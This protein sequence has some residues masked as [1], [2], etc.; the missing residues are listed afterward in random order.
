MRYRCNAV[1][2]GGGVRGIGHVGAASVLE[3][4]G[5]RFCNFVGSSAGAIV[6]SL[7][8]CGYTSKELKE[9]MDNMDY[10]SFRQEGILSYFGT[11][12]KVVA[13]CTGFG[14]YHTDYFEEWLSDLLARKGK[15]TFGDLKTVPSKKQPC[16]WRLQVTASDVTDQRL[17]I[18]PRDLVDFGIDPDS[19]S[20]SEAVQM[21]MSIPLFYK[22]YRLVDADGKEHLI[23]DGGLLSNYPIW[24]FDTEGESPLCP[25]VGFKFMDDDCGQAGYEKEEVIPNFSWYL[26]TLLSTA[27]EAADKQHISE[28]KGDFARTVAIPVTIKI[29]GTCKKIRA[30]DFDITKQESELL[31]EN[32]RGAARTFMRHWNFN[33]WK[34][35]Y[36]RNVI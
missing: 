2:E 23:V 20:I 16:K 11:L 6:A 17:L 26:K 8:A 12:G 10:Q 30:I 36:R 35:H 25:T 5:Y 32:G 31:Y 1:F 15:T 3:E 18:L 7:L 22:P 19:F 24:L 34:N 27:L 14:I 29:E 21:S 4:S 33:T 9:I 28:S 13:L